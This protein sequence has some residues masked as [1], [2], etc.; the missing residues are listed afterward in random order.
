MPAWGASQ[1]E[2]RKQ[3]R[4]RSCSAAPLGETGCPVAFAVS[5]EEFLC[6]GQQQGLGFQALSQ[7]DLQ[8]CTGVT[9]A[10]ETCTVCQASSGSCVGTPTCEHTCTHTHMY[11]HIYMNTHIHIHASTHPDTCTHTCAYRHT[12]MHTYVHEHIHIHTY[13]HTYVHTHAHAHLCTCTHAQ[14]HM[15]VYTH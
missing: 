3:S 12:H 10:P 11:A 1:A 9:L 4:G 6:G 15:C 8:S 7:P 5:W 13:V 2:W 14:I